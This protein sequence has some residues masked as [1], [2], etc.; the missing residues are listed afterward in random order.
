[1]NGADLERSPVILIGTH[2]SGTTM[3]AQMLEELG[4]FL[5]RGDQAHHEALFFKRINRWIYSQVNATWDRPDNMSFFQGAVRAEVKRVDGFAGGESQT[6]SGALMHGAT[7]N[8]VV[9]TIPGAGRIPGTSTPWI[10]GKRSFPRLGFSTSTGIRWTSRGACS[11][12]SSDT[13]SRFE[14]RPRFARPRRS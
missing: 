13:L 3:L 14:I 9:L 4:V 7:K 11:D 6:S 2:R 5:G 12:A 8:S 1:M 10:S